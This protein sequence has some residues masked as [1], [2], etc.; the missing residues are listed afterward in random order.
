MFVRSSYNTD[1]YNEQVPDRDGVYRSSHGYQVDGG[2]DLL[3][4]DL[5]NGEIY[6]GYIQQDYIHFLKPGATTTIPNISG[7]DFGANIN[8]FPTELLTLHLAAS[9][10]L[11]NTV[12]VSTVNSLN[13]ASAG[14]DRNVTLSAE[15][16]LLREVF[17]TGNTGFDDTNYK[18]S[19]REDKTV[20]AGVGGK[21]LI[22]HYLWAD[23]KYQYSI[24]SSS[25]PLSGYDD[26]LVS[27]GLNVQI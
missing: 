9:R 27:I 3:L 6:A 14:D 19:N 7:L 10:Q 15:Y 26:N 22:N 13:V 16:E 12:V 11:E 2:V 5:A 20:F 8:W 1:H 21:W 18:G 24:R 25:V 17:L 4:G 23:V